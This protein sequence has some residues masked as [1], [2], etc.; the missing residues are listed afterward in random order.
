M[1]LPKRVCEHDELWSTH[2]YAFELLPKLRRIRRAQVRLE[3]AQRFPT[4]IDD[5]AVAIGG[6]LMQVERAHALLFE[7]LPARNREGR[8]NSL[9]ISLVHPE[10]HYQCEWSRTVLEHGAKSVNDGADVIFG[11]DRERSHASNGRARCGVL[12]SVRSGPRL[13]SQLKLNQ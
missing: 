5:E 12:Q 6:F 3:F 4:L 7:R 2:D 1:Q 9:P 13:S 10:P 8:N 11:G